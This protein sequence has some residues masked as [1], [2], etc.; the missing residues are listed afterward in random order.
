MRLPLSTQLRIAAALAERVVMMDGQKDE[1]AMTRDFANAAPWLDDLPAG[2]ATGAPEVAL[3]AFLRTDLW[4]VR[5]TLILAHRALKALPDADVL[6]VITGV[7]QTA[8]EVPRETWTAPRAVAT[9]AISEAIADLRANHEAVLS[10]PV[11]D[12]FDPRV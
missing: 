6:R 8:A 10:G 4:H 11:H 3:N 5:E 12:E 7:A 9:A 1:V 2:H